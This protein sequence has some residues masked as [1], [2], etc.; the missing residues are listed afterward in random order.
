MVA[1][2]LHGTPA[3]DQP[4]AQPT[5][6][7]AR[8]EPTEFVPPTVAK[9]PASIPEEMLADPGPVALEDLS[10]SHALAPLSPP[11]R[12]TQG[13]SR[14]VVEVLESQSA[15][16]V[17]FWLAGVVLLSLRH[18]GG[19]LLARRIVREAEP[20]AEGP[21][22]RV[23]DELARRM[24]ISRRLHVLQPAVAQ[25]PMGVGWLCPRCWCRHR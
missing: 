15:W 23:V 3:E 11:N 13:A 8:Y 20:L 6:D 2:G 4:I 10:E 17:P 9:P 19:W 7:A 1:F 22:G 21:L 24:K 12:P 5:V 18:S 25:V 16:L 14:P